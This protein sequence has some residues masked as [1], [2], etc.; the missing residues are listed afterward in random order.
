MSYAKPRPNIKCEKANRESEAKEA[1]A[2]R[3]QGESNR[4]KSPITLPT[5]KSFD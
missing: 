3:M 5:V 4:K 1:R 2:R